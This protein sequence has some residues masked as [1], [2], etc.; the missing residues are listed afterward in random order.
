MELHLQE[1]EGQEL[2]GDG[3]ISNNGDGGTLFTN[4]GKNQ[5]DDRWRLQT[6]LC[7]L[8]EQEDGCALRFLRFESNSRT[9]A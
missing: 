3:R 8:G 4:L 9:A 1:D 7:F 5:N 2:T 6:K